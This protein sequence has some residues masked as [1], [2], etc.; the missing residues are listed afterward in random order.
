ME[1]AGERFWLRK[2]FH[3]TVQFPECLCPVI[4]KQ[5]YSQHNNQSALLKNKQETVLPQI[6]GYADN[7]II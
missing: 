5:T 4:L 7:D 1:E 3:K 6:I 2:S